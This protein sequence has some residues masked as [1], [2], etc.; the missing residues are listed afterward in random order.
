M[1]LDSLKP[2]YARN[3]KE[4][5][6]TNHGDSSINKLTNYPNNTEAYHTSTS[7]WVAIDATDWLVLAA[8]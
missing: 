8:T 1:W 7:A 5:F 4:H 3:G 2:T 6:I